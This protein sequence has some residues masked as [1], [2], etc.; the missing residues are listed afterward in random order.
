MHIVSRRNMQCNLTAL[1]VHVTG[2]RD[3]M[4]DANRQTMPRVSDQALLLNVL[5]VLYIGRRFFVHYSQGRQ[6][7]CHALAFCD[8]TL[9]HSHKSH[10]SHAGE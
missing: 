5:A 8:D 9:L 3:H 1:P 10:K 4:S 7:L 6:Q 2:N